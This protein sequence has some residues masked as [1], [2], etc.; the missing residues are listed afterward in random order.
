[1]T[2]YDMDNQ[3]EYFGM[4]ILIFPIPATCYISTANYLDAERVIWMRSGN[5]ESA[6]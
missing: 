3:F 5:S 4:H 2:R 6:Y 1:M